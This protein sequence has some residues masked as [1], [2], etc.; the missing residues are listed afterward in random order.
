MIM[1]GD[2]E[3]ISDIEWLQNRNRIVSI[4]DG[5]AVLSWDLASECIV[6]HDG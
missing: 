6:P 4:N 2:R 1:T 3:R 5:G